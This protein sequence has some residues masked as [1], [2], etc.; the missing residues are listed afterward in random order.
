MCSF[1][2]CRNGNT[3]TWCSGHIFWL[4]RRRQWNIQS[5]HTNKR[6]ILICK[7]KPINVY[8]ELSENRIFFYNYTVHGG[9]GC[10][11]AP[12][13]TVK[14]QLFFSILNRSESIWAVFYERKIIVSSMQ[15]NIR[16]KITRTVD[17][18]LAPKNWEPR[19]QRTNEINSEYVR[20]I[21][22]A[23]YEH[24]SEK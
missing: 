11:G 23:A 24:M 3:N 8:W 1:S 13:P 9:D 22:R 17:V 18:I 12:R 15:H 19:G 16:P 21:I 7:M 4:I 5:Q 14:R 2:L 20:R 6:P 10:R